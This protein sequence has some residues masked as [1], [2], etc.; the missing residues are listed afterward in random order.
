MTPLK[1]NQL[2][3]KMET[4][5]ETDN[6]MGNGES[7]IMARSGEEQTLLPKSYSDWASLIGPRLKQILERHLKVR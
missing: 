6:M 5:M 4:K 7:D 2:I 1:A 3:I